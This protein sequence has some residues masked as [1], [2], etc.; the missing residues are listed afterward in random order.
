MLEGNRPEAFSSTRATPA[1]ETEHRGTA[2]TVLGAAGNAVLGRD[3]GVGAHLKASAA[4]LARHNLD[5]RVL[6]E[7]VEPGEEMPGVHR[8]SQSRAVQR[9]HAG[10]RRLGAALAFPPA[11][12]H[13]HQP[14]PR[15][16][17]EL[18]RTAAPVLISV[19]SYAAC[20]SGVHHF[21]PGNEC[22]RAHGPGCMLNLT[23]RGCA[24]TRH[25]KHFPAKYNR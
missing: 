9:T 1:P 12:I 3:G 24:H 2:S 6:A 17:V 11:V 8:I 18:M 16:L 14:A 23:V 4:L 7:R 19:H 21:S 13:L 25:L 10:E 5:V 20:T 22:T 15:E